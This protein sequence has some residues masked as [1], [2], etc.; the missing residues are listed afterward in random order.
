MAKSEELIFSFDCITSVKTDY[1]CT[2]IQS[3]FKIS[4]S[5]TQGYV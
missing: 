2:T 4:R 5:G 1:I 3:Y